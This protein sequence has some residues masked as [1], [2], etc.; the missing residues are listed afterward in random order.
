MPPRILIF[1]A[2]SGDAPRTAAGRACEAL[3]AGAARPLA[4]DPART[5]AG[6]RRA[7]DHLAEQLA[8][9]PVA[10]AMAVLAH[11]TGLLRERADATVVLE[12]D[13]AERLVD[14]LETADLA[15]ARLHAERPAA[16]SSTLA[17][18]RAGGAPDLPTLR[19][20]A[21][22]G[23]LLRARELTTCG[24]I[25]GPHAAPGADAAA[26]TLLALAGL[27]VLPEPLPDEPAEAAAAL[28][29]ATPAAAPDPA[30]V[31]R[32]GATAAT[33][34]LTL[35]AI[36]QDLRAVRSQGEVALQSAGRS[37]R[38]EAPRCLGVL[39]PGRVRTGTDTVQI[40]FNGPSA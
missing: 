40:A 4:V 8:L 37:R 29:R 23:D 11:L 27:P 5:P 6:I 13:R 3:P 26:R 30:P 34:E 10:H 22:A 9:R 35:P 25:P 21:A 33:I 12:A 17:V 31:V 14:L 15:R 18:A 2:L 1:A 39:T 28:L 32:P 20:A 38:L 16:G 7:A 24:L 19:A 36:P